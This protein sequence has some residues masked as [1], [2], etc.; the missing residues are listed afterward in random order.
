MKKSVLMKGRKKEGEKGEKEI[1][2]GGIGESVH[3]DSGR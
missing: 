3:P 2:N 1:K